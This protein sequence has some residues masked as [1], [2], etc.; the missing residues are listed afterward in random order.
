MKDARSA[1]VWRW[2]LLGLVVFYGLLTFGLAAVVTLPA[3]PSP[4]LVAMARAAMPLAQAA[5]GVGLWLQVID[6]RAMLGGVFPVSMA[7]VL[8][9]GVAGIGCIGRAQSIQSQIRRDADIAH[10]EAIR[11]RVRRKQG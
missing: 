7:G 3:Q 1:A 5:P 10:D 4:F 6:V 9:F 2:R 11:E 8:I